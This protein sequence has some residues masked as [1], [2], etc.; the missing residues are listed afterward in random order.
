MNTYFINEL[1]RDVT[2][3]ELRLCLKFG[4]MECFKK[5][6]Q[7]LE[8]LNRNCFLSSLITIYDISLTAESFQE[9]EDVA[10]LTIDMVNNKMRF[11]YWNGSEV[12]WSFN[13]QE[14]CNILL[15][16]REEYAKIYAKY[17]PIT[18]TIRS[19]ENRYSTSIR[20]VLYT[21]YPLEN[22]DIKYLIIFTEDI[23]GSE[24]HLLKKINDEI[25]KLSDEVTKDLKFYIDFDFEDGECIPCKEAEK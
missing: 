2:Y 21:Y 5:V 9:R 22:M 23:K 15:E 8:F 10:S 6:N 11:K 17:Y 4:C 20:R 16:Q 7:I 1:N 3:I 18:D 24:G 13:T 25:N 14:L 12:F 19:I